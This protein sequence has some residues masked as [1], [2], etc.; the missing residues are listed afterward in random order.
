MLDRASRKFVSYDEL[1]FQLHFLCL[2]YFLNLT[3]LSGLKG[4]AR[5]S[6]GN[7]IKDT[8]IICFFYPNHDGSIMVSLNQKLKRIIR[9]AFFI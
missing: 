1:H 3:P 8:L 2:K 4:N 6:M 5:R 7:R 9:N